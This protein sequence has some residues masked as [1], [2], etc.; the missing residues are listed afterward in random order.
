MSPKRVKRR[1]QRIRIQGKERTGKE[2]EEE[3]RLTVLKK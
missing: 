2:E 3:K 1:R